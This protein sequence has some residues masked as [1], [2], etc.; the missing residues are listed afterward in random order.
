MNNNFDLCVPCLLGLEGPIADE[1]KRMKLDNVRSENG[2]VYFKGGAQ[3]IAK[4]NINLRIGERVLVELG[5]FE[6]RSFDELFEKTKAL[7]WEMLIPRDA[8]FPVKGYSLNSKLFS[9][10]DCQ[11]IIK[12]A[13]VERLKKRVRHRV[14]RRDGGNISD[15]VFHNEGCCVFV[16]RYLRSGAS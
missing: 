4:A 10:S 14:V 8:A 15:T 12:K 3:A 5:R 2:R 7:P 1:L 13:V 6:A 16:H 9:V 11:K